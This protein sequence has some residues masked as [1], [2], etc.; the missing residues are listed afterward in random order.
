MCVDGVNDYTC[1]CPGDFGGKFC[2]VAPMVALMYPQT[3]P[4][5]N[6]ECR[7]GI[8]MT[9]PGAQDY[10]C[11]CS[12]GFSGKLCEYLTTIS[13]LHNASFA[14]LEP[15]RTKPEAN[16]TMVLTTDHENGV[17]M[18]DGTEA[19]HFGAELFNGRVRVSYDVGNT[20][21]STIYSFEVISDG[22][23]HIIELLSVGKNFTLRVDRGLPRSIIN[24][25]DKDQLR[26]T[27]PLFIGG[28]SLEAGQEAF[29]NWHLRNL[30][31]FRGML[32]GSKLFV[33]KTIFF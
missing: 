29:T 11:R 16:I 26:L 33:K 10:I 2:E 30:T 25:G 17:L 27:T 13:F 31:S 23:P 5:Q 21:F 7:N 4:C 24:E 19:Q 15:L 6:H 20:P 14:E 28:V 9:P 12:P 32:S 1:K 22:K 18:Y 3:S 8:C